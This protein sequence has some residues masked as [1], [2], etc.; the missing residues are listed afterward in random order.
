MLRGELPPTVAP[1]WIEWDVAQPPQ[2]E[3]EEPSSPEEDPF[4]D[5]NSWAPFLQPR[6]KR[7]R[8]VTVDESS[9][10]DEEDE[11]EEAE[12]FPY[13]VGTKIARDFGEHGIYWGVIEKHY[14]D[15]SNL[16]GVRFTDGDKEDLDQD[17]IQYAIQ[18]YEQEFG[19]A[20]SE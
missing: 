19:V 16:C 13:P 6:R 2:S 7:A 10:E 11:E 4:D 1:E 9:S 12:S 20:N 17:E 8:T 3:E 14:P 18:L 15:D 5:E